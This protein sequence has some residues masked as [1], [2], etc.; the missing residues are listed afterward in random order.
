MPDTITS[1][2]IASSKIARLWRLPAESLLLL[3]PRV[4]GST[5]TIRV[6]VSEIIAARRPANPGA[7]LRQQKCL[8]ILRESLR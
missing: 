1:R 4:F 5:V 6:R 3:A 7:M 8:E 2:K